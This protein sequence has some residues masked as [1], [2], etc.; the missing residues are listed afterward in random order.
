MLNMY[1]LSSS[2]FFAVL[3]RC[4]KAL[5][6][7]CLGEARKGEYFLDVFLN[8]DYALGFF[9]MRNPDLQTVSN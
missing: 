1:T 7:F 5:I 3:A 4:S 6:L 8:P 9:K 2:I